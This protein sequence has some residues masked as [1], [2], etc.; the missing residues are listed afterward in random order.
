MKFLCTFCILV[1]AWI[2]EACYG[3]TRGSGPEKHH[4]AEGLYSFS[5]FLRSADGEKTLKELQATGLSYKNS[6]GHF[7]FLHTYPARFKTNEHFTF[8]DLG[9]D[10]FSK[11]AR[12]PFDGYHGN[13]DKWPKEKLAP[14]FL[15]ASAAHIIEGYTGPEHGFPPVVSKI[16]QNIP[17]FSSLEE[18][19]KLPFRIGED[20][21]PSIAIRDWWAAYEKKKPSFP[22]VGRRF[23]QKAVNVLGLVNELGPRIN[24]G[25]AEELRTK[26]VKRVLEEISRN[27]SLVDFGVLYQRLKIVE[28]KDSRN[29]ELKDFLDRIQEVLSYWIDQTFKYAVL[30]IML[31]QPIEG[32]ARDAEIELSH[33]LPPSL[34]PD[35]LMGESQKFLKT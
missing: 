19:L 9:R 25:F 1:S 30:H 32:S 6:E 35:L 33:I 2:G 10:L 13:G 28:E 23:A 20:H 21:V 22:E 31:G 11:G 17:V 15:G 14:I 3:A 34:S 5:D 16:W 18:A 24:G 12:D 26:F 7:V 4:P 29:N 27:E 8:S